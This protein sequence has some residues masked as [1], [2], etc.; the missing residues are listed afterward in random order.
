MTFIVSAGS[1]DFT[2][3][4]YHR[5]SSP[6]QRVDEYPVA[7][8]FSGRLYQTNRPGSRIITPP[9]AVLAAAGPVFAFVQPTT[10]VVETQAPASALHHEADHDNLVAASSELLLVVIVIVLAGWTTII[11]VVRPVGDTWR[12]EPQFRR[13]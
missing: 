1:G 4:Q 2:G 7:S 10:Y 8:D 6:P 3:R 5:S 9:G 12:D 11:R 13:G